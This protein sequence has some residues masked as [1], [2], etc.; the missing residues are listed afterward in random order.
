MLNGAEVSDDDLCASFRAVEA[1]RGDTSLTYFEF[2]TLAALNWFQQ[3]QVDACVLEIGLGGRLDAVNMV[4]PDISVVTSIGLDHQ[5]WLGDTV[6]Q[7]AYEKVSIARA[8]KALVCGQPNPP[9]TARATAENIGAQWLCRDQDFFIEPTPQGLALR[10]VQNDEQ[11]SWLLPA[12]NIPYHNVATAVQTLALLGRLPAQAVVAQVISELQVAGRLQRYVR[13]S[14]DQA[15]QLT[16]DVAHNEQAAAYVGSQLA[17]VDGIILGMLSD[18][19]VNEVVQAL[20]VTDHWFLAGLEGPRALRGEQL[21]ERAEVLT[22]KA[23]YCFDS[24]AAA[25]NALPDRGHWLVCGSFYTVEA[26]LEWMQQQGPQWCNQ[27]TG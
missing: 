20:P 19:P 4:E 16:L 22:G 10:F 1:V 9:L 27:Q 17:D 6:E 12:A 13:G 24:V 8:G 14:G 3:Q 25:L 15:L 5:A 23:V 7:I 11:P 2:G 18:K 26:A 21:L